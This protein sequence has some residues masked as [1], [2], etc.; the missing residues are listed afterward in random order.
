VN[1]WN[2]RWRPIFRSSLIGLWAILA[3]SLP[4]HAAPQRSPVAAAQVCYGQGDLGCVVQLLETANA[5]AADAPE[6][7]RLLGFAAARL[8]RHDLAR[9][10]FAEWIALSPTH[11]LDRTM[12]PPAIYQDYT[13]A[14]LERHGAELDLTPRTGDRPQAPVPPTQV[15]AL[16]K[17]APPPRAER[18]QA[19]DF[20]FYAGIAVAEYDGIVGANPVDHLGGFLGI[21]HDVGGRFRLGPQLGVWQYG[22]PNDVG[23]ETAR[24]TAFGLMRA[25]VLLAGGGGHSVEAWLGLGGGYEPDEDVAGAVAPAVRYTFRPAAGRSKIAVTCE[26]AAVTLVA[27]DELRQLFTLG[28]GVGLRDT[29]DVGG[30][31]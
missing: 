13:A 2:R 8:D 18:D 15:V 27:G 14:L 24:L 28:V 31:R 10:A 9:K 19:T 22:A 1:G 23:G 7:W 4:A 11:R 5:S 21:E 3:L 29:K 6:R 12:T 26:V 25:G 30:A 20:A 17:F 16:P